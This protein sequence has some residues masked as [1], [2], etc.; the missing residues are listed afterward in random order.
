MYNVSMYNTQMLFLNRESETE[1]LEKLTAKKTSSLTVIWGRRRIGKTR[2]LLEWLKRHQGLYWVADESVPALQRRYLSLVLDQKLPGFSSVEYPDWGTLFSRLAKEAKIA[3]WRGPLVIDELPYL[4]ESSPELPSIIQ[5]FVDHEGKEVN[6]ILALCGSSQRMM[7]G[8]ILDSNEPLYGRAQEII[9][10]QPLHLCYL[11]EIIDFTDAKDLIK[12]YAIWGGIPR[13]WELAAPFG[14]DIYS[15]IDNLVLDP[16]GVLYDETQR[17]LIEETPPATTLRPLLDAIGFGSHRLSEIAS[18][19]NLPATSLSRPLDRLKILDFI[20]REV[21]FGSSEKE[22]KRALYKI[23]D[24]FLRFW[25]EC[26][27]PKRSALA[28]I[29]KSLRISWLKE[30]LPSIWSKSWE[31]ICRA[32]IPALSHKLNNGIFKPA[33]RYWHGNGSEWDIVS[34]SFDKK[35]LLL[36][37][38][39]WSENEIS[40]NFVQG[41]LN[42]LLQKGTPF[43]I[44]PEISLCYAIFVPEK[45]KEPLELPKNVFLFEA[46]DIIQKPKD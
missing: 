10:L 35:T 11:K 29:G 42:E 1:R 8:L 37:E 31:E 2:L 4:V 3:N 46:K 34:E 32:S 26:V 18:R 30:T 43:P 38:A 27:A 40:A 19:L 23:K 39:K 9:K 25:F 41:I 45:P 13:Y 5:R 6:F 28:Q 14:R 20:E 21:P 22:T 24:P 7:Q 17:L 33:Q 12:T 36:G 44:G 15:A 16:Q